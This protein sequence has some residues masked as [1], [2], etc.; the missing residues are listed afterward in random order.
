MPIIAN[1]GKKKPGP[2]TLIA[3]MYVIL[4]AG[5]ISMVY[6]FMIWLAKSF[7]SRADSTENVVCPRFITSDDALFRKYLNMRY[8]K[9]EI[10]TYNNLHRTRYQDFSYGEIIA[11]R[12]ESCNRVINTLHEKAKA[13]KRENDEAEKKSID[14][15]RI[16]IGNMERWQKIT[17]LQD[18]ISMP[19]IKRLVSD[20]YEFLSDYH[21]R[22]PRNLETL[23]RTN[24]LLFSM[25]PLN[26]KYHRWL[27]RQA[28]VT[29]EIEKDPN[30]TPLSIIAHR[31]KLEYSNIDDILPPREQPGTRSWIQGNSLWEQDW[32]KFKDELFET[33]P[34]YFII[35]QDEY[36]NMAM[37][38]VSSIQNYNMIFGTSYSSLYELG[39]SPSVPGTE[40]DSKEWIDYISSSASDISELDLSRVENDLE[41]FISLRF[42][43]NVALFNSELS[44]GYFSFAEAVKSKTPFM[45]ANEKG[46]II[47][48]E[49]LNS[50]LKSAMMIWPVGKILQDHDG[51]RREIVVKFSKFMK[52]SMWI[53]YAVEW[54]TVRKLEIRNA[55]LEWPAFVTGWF[56]E[57]EKINMENGSLQPFS[58]MLSSGDAM[59]AFPEETLLKC[60][61]K[62]FHIG[63]DKITDTVYYVTKKE[64]PEIKWTGEPFISRELGGLI[65][66]FIRSSPPENIIVAGA[67]FE[68]SSFLESKYRD[69]AALNKEYCSEFR[70]FRELSIPYPIVE[71]SDF[72]PVRKELKRK[73]L[74]ANFII[75]G[76]FIGVRGNSLWNTIIFIC[77]AIFTGLTVNPLCA[78][79]LSR[80]KMSYS[81]NILLFCLAT[82]AFPT[83]VTDIP[84]FLLLKEMNLLNTYW[85]LILPGVANGYSI[86]IL[87]GFFDSLP[88]ELYEAG[89]IDG[90]TEW[91]MFYMVAMP[92]SKPVLAVTALGIFTTAYSAWFFAIIIC[93]NPKMWTIAV[94]LYQFRETYLYAPQIATAA[95]VL[96]SI[97]I[98]IIFIFAQ[99]IIIK[100]IVVPQMK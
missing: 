39:I 74:E 67:D 94:F 13:E 11:D 52:R 21:K 8:A 14:N 90:A 100:G 2:A 84:N 70:S 28:W 56:A 29:Q 1:I 25:N 55:A 64:A 43:G 18:D 50:D 30:K 7:S 59:K 60:E 53:Y 72:M 57:H 47:F 45:S 51:K 63:S 96:A 49:F 10:D 9:G 58:I 86:F 98:L 19:Q 76:D 24:P 42:N 35:S 31:Y 32:E 37:R 44:T 97:P 38:I 99:R 36:R 66:E 46:R 48:R 17:L 91:Q 77:A 87:K 89:T 75:A 20:Y 5:S 95:Q 54:E 41:L 93:Q 27:E 40:A 6:P 62:E 3:I 15:L 88:Q 34:G 33:D 80:F 16:E 85:A 81:H 79:A 68:Y 65:Y 73:F 23:F 82:M 12:I 71:K 22:K 61:K 78:Y 4:V 69:I 92:L 83:Q 26:D